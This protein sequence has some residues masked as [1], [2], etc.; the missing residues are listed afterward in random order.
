MGVS[1]IGGPPIETIMAGMDP[2]RAPYSQ[3]RLAAG[4]P[5]KEEGLRLIAPGPYLGRGPS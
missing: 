1:K 2:Y 5:K 4:I 3:L